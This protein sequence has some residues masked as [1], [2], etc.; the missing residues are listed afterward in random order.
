MTKRCFETGHP[1]EGGRF[2]LCSVV[3]AI[4]SLRELTAS[5]LAPALIEG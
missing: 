3:L 1:I 4:V 2:H 5:R